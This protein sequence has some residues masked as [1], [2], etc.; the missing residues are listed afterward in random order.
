MAFEPVPTPRTLPMRRSTPCLSL[1]LLVAAGM[2]AGCS[3]GGG[4]SGPGAGSLGEFQ[5]SSINVPQ[6]AIWQVNRAFEFTF[7]HAVD[8]SSVGPNTIN[9]QTAAGVPAN[10]VF[11]IKRIDTDGDG[12]RET[13]LPAVVVFQPNCPTRPDKT[14]SGLEI[15]SVRYVITVVGRSSGSQDTVRSTDGVRLEVTQSRSFFTPVSAE[16]TTAFL[17]TVPGPPQPVVRAAGSTRTEGVSYFECGGDPDDRV[18]FEFDEGTQQYSLSQAGFAAP[19]NL[20]SDASSRIAAVI[21]FDQPVSPDT[22]NINP[23]FIT[24]ETQDPGGTWRPFDT[25]VT[26]VAN[27]TESGATVRLDPIG[28]LPVASN[29]RVAVNPGFVDLTGQEDNPQPLNSFARAPTRSI[30][31]DSLSPAED[32]ADEIFEGFAIGGEVAGSREDTAIQFDTPQARWGGGALR[33]AFDFTGTGGPTPQFDWV[34]LANTTAFL[35]TVSDQIIGGENGAPEA[36]ENVVGGVVDVRNLVIEEGAV[37]RIQGRNPLRI[38]ATGDVIIRGTLDISGFNAKNVVSLD[39]GN[40]PEAGGIGA[41]GGGNG[42]AASTVTNNSTP[43]GQTGFGPGQVP[44]LGGKGGESSYSPVNANNVEKRRPGGG[45]GGRFAPDVP[46]DPDFGPDQLAQ[47]TEKT[48]VPDAYGMKA[49]KGFNGAPDALGALTD[50]LTPQGGD[51]GVGPFADG[52]STNDFWGTRPVADTVNGGTLFIHGE[53]TGLTAGYGGGGGGDASA[54]MTFPTPNWSIASDEKGGGGG[55]GGGGL[56]I[57]AIGDIVFGASGQILCRGG[58]GATGENTNFID[59]IGGGGGGGSGGH[60]VLETASK[61][62]FTDGSPTNTGAYGTNP[63]MTEAGDPYPLGGRPRILANG[64]DGATIGDNTPGMGD[65]MPVGLGYGGD[66][67]PGVIQLHV[68]RP[69]LPAS[70]RGVAFADSDII[71]FLAATA[72]TDPQDRLRTVMAPAGVAL[73]PTF[74]ARSQ[75]RSDWI[76]LGLADQDPSGGLDKQISFFF[77]GIDPMTGEV[78]TDMDGRVEAL[79]PLLEGELGD[80]GVSVNVAGDQLTLAGAAIDP[81]VNDASV[82]SDDI[83]LRTPAL[84]RNFA[85]RLTTAMAAPLVLDVTSASYDD[86]AVSLA[87]TVDV[88]TQGTTIQRYVSDHP[89]QTIGYELIPRFF[90]LST[91]GALDRVGEGATVTI[92]FQATAADA[93]GNPDEE[94]ILVDFTSDISE[95]NAVPPGMIQ[96]VRFQVEFDL[97]DGG[98]L[99][100]DTEPTELDYLR[101]PFRF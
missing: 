87:L 43:V 25:Q 37:L 51:P 58:R 26:L 45:G 56:H 96:F 76:T 28:I 6:N 34:I 53:L 94:N 54:A 48:M 35:D 50:A 16:N 22:S 74:S 84:L 79:D 3:G 90:R 23:T 85:L 86:M 100:V 91:D 29:V 8:F 71:V 31:F 9:I 4:G 101:L 65:T 13:T 21:V 27:C 70:P 46:D 62:D 60:V 38:N 77:D 59:H 67:G 97:A 83:Y 42:G 72:L 55:A 41:G 7:S 30:L 39:T 63:F 36:I 18:F 64:G 15:G 88:G 82:P 68:P 1:S 98:E 99:S 20:Y 52:D 32:G 75:A 66:G 57:K 40:Q 47:L 24:F 33:A 12:V 92:S 14:D 10:G 19:L 95:F 81:L 11:S 89:G 73:V 61:I 44:D 93:F 2:L 49:R 80:A 17:D 5:L 78:L 69:L